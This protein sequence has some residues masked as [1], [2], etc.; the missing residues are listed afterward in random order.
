MTPSDALFWYAESV[1]PEFRPIIAGLYL[2]DRA[3]DPQ[4]IE[5][6]ADLALALVPR[7]RQRVIEAP[8]QLGLPEWVE[9]E[10]FDR[11]YHLRHLSLPAP[12]TQRQLLDLAATLFATPLDRQRPL[13][14][15]YWIDGLEGGR[16]AYFFK[17]HHSVVDG[18]GS[19]A[20]LEALTS[21]D[22]REP[23]PRVRRRRGKRKKRER[24]AATTGA[25]LAAL[26]REQIAGS[27]GLARRAF[28]APFATLAHPRASV[29]TAARVVRG[30][31]GVLADAAA[32]TPPRDPLAVEGS[33]LSRRL[34]VAEVPLARLKKI[35]APL[36]VSLNDVVLAALAGALRAY[37]RE[38]RVHADELVCMVPMNLRGQ[39]ERD[40][41]GNRVGVF[42][43]V[44]PVGEPKVERR[45]ARIV[46]QTRAAKSDRRGAAAPFLVEALTL[47]P[48]PAFRWLGRN[49]IGRV[50][51]AC[52][53]VPGVPTRRW[54]AGARV[55]AI[56]PFASVVEGTPLILA[57]VSYAGQMELGIDTDPE[58]IPDPHRIALLFEEALADLEKL[59]ARAS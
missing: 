32:R 43:V 57:L 26:A 59:A 33:G 46:E 28:G 48:A 24:G 7:L 20:L 9:D 6:G 29:E 49:A 30:L 15:S 55:D 3:P 36:G 39:D 1:L 22:P 5:A 23:P 53:N 10:H 41:L 38:R 45:L 17:T 2:L 4:R 52:T 34:D 27:L 18:V 35:K 31:R 44:L 50:N 42:N 8:L 16:S 56:Y 37:H 11:A 54:M 13:W 12:G 51:V 58:A 14:E 21:A 19:V 47:L 25:R 40:T